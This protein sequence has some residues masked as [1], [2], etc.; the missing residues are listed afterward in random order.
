MTRPCT[1]R[2]TT[3]RP[4]AQQRRGL[5]HRGGA[6]RGGHAGRRRRHRRRAASSAAGCP[7]SGQPRAAA[8][9]A[10]PGSAARTSRVASRTSAASGGQHGVDRGEHLLGGDPGPGA[11]A[12]P[13]VD[14]PGAVGQR[15]EQRGDVP[16]ERAVGQ[17]AELPQPRA[18]G[19]RPRPVEAGAGE[20]VVVAEHRRRVA[21]HDPPVDDD[22][23][24][25]G[26]AQR[27]VDVVGAHDDRGP[28]RLEPGQRGEGLGDRGGVQ[29]RRRLVEQ[30][31]A[32]AHGDRAGDRHPLALAVGELVGRP[33]GEAV[34]GEQPQRLGDP[35]ADGVLGQ[36][37]VERAERDVLGDRGAEQLVVGVLQDQLH[38]LPVGAQPAAVVLQQLRRR[39]RPRPRRAP[40]RRT[41]SAAASSCP[42]R[43]RPAAP[44]AGRR[45]R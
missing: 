11:D 43:S 30:Q 27:E 41:G 8:A 6:H 5:G 23:D 20:Q 45:G 36:A 4:A 19:Q 10:I 2:P 7:V 44:A 39:R 32:G 16:G 21:L 12:D 29:A 28:G 42:S 35:L 15:G 3:Q 25:V 40:A 17:Q 22:G 31:H 14:D 24:L 38:L 13:H 37:Q 26:P 18:D 9:A 33:G 1:V 34:D